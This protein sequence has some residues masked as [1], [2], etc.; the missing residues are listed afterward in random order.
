[1]L[2]KLTGLLSLSGAISLIGCETVHLPFK[3]LIV[4]NLE[5]T[6]FLQ[7]LSLLEPLVVRSEEHRYIPD[8]RF[9]QIMDANAETATD[10]SHITI[11]VDAR[12]ETETIDDEDIIRGE[13]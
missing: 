7:A 11:M 9:Q 12:Q 6:V 2:N 8:S 4:R 5:A 13:R 1:M 3:V 10:I